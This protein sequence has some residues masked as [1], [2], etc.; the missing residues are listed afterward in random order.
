MQRIQGKGHKTPTKVKDSKFMV[1]VDSF[2]DG[3]PSG[4]FYYL[5]SNEAYPF[6]DLTELILK[7]D[8]LLDQ[9]DHPQAF[10]RHRMWRGVAT[11]WEELIIPTEE[12]VSKAHRGQKETFSLAVI[13]RQHGSWQG[14]VNWLGRNQ[15]VCFRSA[16][17]LLGLL[18][19]ACTD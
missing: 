2:E 11:R 3:R 5:H 17:E 15:K 14:G 13:Q 10:I 16:L 7:I 9:L 8:R 1:C 4:R 19:S 18:Q 12:P 6:H